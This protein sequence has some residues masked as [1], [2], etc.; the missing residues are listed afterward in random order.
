MISYIKRHPYAVGLAFVFHIIIALFLIGNFWSKPTII[1]VQDSGSALI[2]PEVTPQMPLTTMTVDQ[3]LIEEQLTRIRE[4]ESQ[5]QAEQ[6]RQLTEA[7]EREQRIAQLQ[8]QQ[9]E[10]ARRAEQARRQAEQERQRIDAERQRAEAEQ[11]RAEEARRVAAQAEQQRAQAERDRAR[12]EQQAREAAEQAQRQRQAEER[13][14]AE[15]AELQKQAEAERAREEARQREVAEQ[16]RQQEAERARLAALAEEEARE[17]EAARQ[18]EVRNLRQSYV[19]SI[20]AKVR[21]N[22]RTPADIS[23]EA[24]CELVIVQDRDGTVVS[25]RTESC[26]PQASEQFK[27]AAER[28]VL[29]A[30]PLPQAPVAEVYERTIRF[31]FRP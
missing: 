28:A 9:E 24:Q 22:W 30:S 29:R 19:S 3:S 14:L 4:Q 16:T 31:V 21:E 23:A 8:R 15:L 20:T 12:A 11:R 6:Q 7:R 10:E 2:Q 18:R 17:R 26:N 1:T 25:V 5:R 27:Q 13:R